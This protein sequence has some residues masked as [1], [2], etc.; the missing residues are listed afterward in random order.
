[1]AKEPLRGRPMTNVGGGTI[2]FAVVA[3][4]NVVVLPLTGNQETSANNT[5]TT[6]LLLLVVGTSP[7]FA[8]GIFI[9]F[10]SAVNEEPIMMVMVVG[11]RCS[12]IQK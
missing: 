3:V 5:T 10:L 1:M 9:F 12:S 8:V 4:A 2:D 11:R 6:T 7:Q